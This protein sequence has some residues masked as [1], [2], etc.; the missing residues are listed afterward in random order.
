[1]ER[2]AQARVEFA[3]RIGE[4]RPDQLIFVDESSVDRRN[5]IPWIR[6]VNGSKSKRK[7]KEVIVKVTDKSDD[8]TSSKPSSVSG[9]VCDS[10]FQDQ[11]LEESF[12]L[13]Y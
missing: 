10:I 4:Y 6:L 2:N 8:V 5:N 3:A 12:Y 9:K 1:L 11:A 13:L 7:M